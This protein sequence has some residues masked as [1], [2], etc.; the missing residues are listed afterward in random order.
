MVVDMSEPRRRLS[1]ADRRDQLLDVARALVE[2]DGVAACTVDSVSQRAGVTPQLVHKYFGTRTSLLQDLF[3]RE[4]E[5]YQADIRTQ[6]AAAGDFEDVVRV[7]VTANFD[8]LSSATAIG[9][10]RVVPE[11]ATIRNERE[12][13]EGRG[14]ERV[15]VRA[16]AAEYPTSPQATEFVLRLGSAAS[17]EA[18]NLAAQRPER[19]RDQDIENTVRFILA[20][21]RELTTEAVGQRAV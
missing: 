20:G 14:A 19:D 7:F 10:L 18:G 21:I 11:I 16:M 1:P 9:R 5:R 15:L 13:A 12:R 17:I 6:I 4:D 3:R 8:Q 2:A